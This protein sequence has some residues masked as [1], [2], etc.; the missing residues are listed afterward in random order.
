MH[1][2]AAWNDAIP[3]LFTT[4]A[5]SRVFRGLGV[6]KA[7]LLAVSSGGDLAV[8]LN[9]SFPFAFGLKGTLAVVRE[10]G[11]APRELATDVF[12][13]DWAPDGKTLAVVRGGT[14]GTTLEYP[15]GTVVYRSTG[16]VS[17]P[18]I[19]PSG[20]RI[21]FLDHPRRRR[22]RRHA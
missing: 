19:S 12:Y 10:L 6:G 22:Q 3:E 11:G 21:A 4:G 14:E 9:P 16:F 18:R 1:F 2:S 15:L 5:D 13:A 7:H 8:L 17:D 20:D